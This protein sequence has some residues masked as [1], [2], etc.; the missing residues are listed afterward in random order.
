MGGL[1]LLRSL[2]H[3][4][5]VEPILFLS[6]CILGSVLH[7]L[8]VEGATNRS[9]YT[10]S[11]LV[12]GFALLH[13]N[14]PLAFIVIIISN[15]AEWL[16]N[17]PP[18]FIQL[19][20][21]GC[22]ALSAQV[23]LLTYA[24]VNPHGI[25]TS[26]QII[27]AIVVGMA[28]FT[29]INHLIVGIVV[30]L[31]RGENFKQSGI[32]D[33]KPLLIDS[34]MLTVGASLTL[35]WN[36]NPYALI[37]FLAAVY[38]LY[39]TLKIPALERKTEIDQKTGLYN[40]Q[41][42]MNQLNNELQRANRYDRP[43]SIIMADLDL[44]RNIN[45][46][47]GHL[48]G[49]DV[50]KGV[51]NT[52]KQAV[53]D[54]DI[55]A[56]FG[57]EEFA[58]LL[59]ETEI[60]KAIQRAEHIRRAIESSSFVI[61]TS[62]EPIKVTMSFGIAKRENFEQS[63]DEL[64]HHAD[65]ALYKSKLSGR[66]QTLAYVNSTFLSTDPVDLSIHP[67]ENSPLS[68]NIPLDEGLSNDYP[69][70]CSTY[71]N[72]AREINK[73]ANEDTA[74]PESRIGENPKESRKSISKV[75]N[76][77]ILLGLFTAV[78]LF[79][80]GRLLVDSV[81]S[82]SP[83][84][85]LGLAS[86][87]LVI[88]LTEWFSVNLYVKNTALSTSAVPIAASII[89]FGPLGTLVAS[90]VFAITAAFKYRSPVNRIVFNF[91]NHILTGM[92]IN[93]LIHVSGIE[94]G[95]WKYPLL[96]LAIVLSASIIMF[97]CTTVLISIGIGI[98]QGQSS[99]AIWKE[100]YSWMVAYYIG[101]GFITFALM[102]GYV[103]A[104]LLGIVTMIIPLALLRIS[105]VQ[106]VEHTRTIVSEIRSKNQELEKITLEISAMN[107]GLLI[108]L[109]E[110]IDLQDPYVLGHSKQVSKYAAE[111]AKSLGLNEKQTDLI[112][113]AG[114][115][116]DI[117]KLGI[118][119]EILTKPARLTPREFEIIKTHPILGSELLKNSP[120]L[121]SLIP[122]V[123]HHHEF[124]NG[125]GYPDK[126]SGNQIPIEARIVAVADAIEAMISDRP[127]RKALKPQDIIDELNKHS[128]TQF[129]P[130]VVRE[131]IKILT[132]LLEAENGLAHQ[133]FNEKLPPQLKINM[134][135]T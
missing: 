16:W 8:K 29:F 77:I 11:F 4:A 26:W 65:T 99:H 78:T 1:L 20:N 101:M 56:R 66:N 102:F 114:L 64:L 48:A 27:L 81:L 14:N 9:H 23:A 62:V 12:F 107:E 109:S 76:Y 70:S 128:G 37:V 49:D 86:I 127:Y 35:V 73:P 50:L 21:I 40:H 111:M 54:Y 130:L 83:I 117:G 132:P 93:L 115:L 75:Y 92:L 60:E 94:V 22:Y 41:Y 96:E 68:Q 84:D 51:A 44:L 116:H 69:A 79:V 123:R 103:Y 85:W 43:F 119:K 33:I 124:Y 95:S 91:S 87:A 131:A 6:L 61:P 72:P 39:M 38:P 126:L 55:V 80:T 13:F 98:D 42:F 28:S 17:R 129:D 34:I 112:R 57:G 24:F 2:R 30:W 5:L 100:Q 121:R 45:N 36:Y 118:S 104:G 10:F 113:R 88:I 63:P 59:P 15:I 122:I 53:R 108:T 134:Q 74:I 7:I 3:I 31:A 46:T 90:T 82:Y 67:M 133:L 105:Q 106:Y 47:Y 71:L 135:A 52:L 25:P 110:I 18:W 19:F 120:S 32:F 58:I 89:L 125:E 97:V